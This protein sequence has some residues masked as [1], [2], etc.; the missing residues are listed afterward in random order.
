MAW[1]L[2]IKIVFGSAAEREAFAALWRPL[3]DYCRANEPRTLA[4][5]LLLS[6]KDEATACIFERYASKEDLTTHQQSEPF[7]A[8]KAA[9]AQA[10]AEG[11]IRRVSVDGHS[12]NES[13]AGYMHRA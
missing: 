2:S 1:V 12:Y 10:E 9:L 4:Y 11:A 13:G 7:K 5:E 6:D 8:F 3:A